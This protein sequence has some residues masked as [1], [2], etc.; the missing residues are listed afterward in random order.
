SATPLPAQPG[1]VGKPVQRQQS[2]QP[3]KKPA[4]SPPSGVVPAVCPVPAGK[5][6]YLPLKLAS[7][8]PIE[9]VDS[10]SPP[11]SG[12]SLG[13]SSEPKPMPNASSAPQR[14]PAGVVDH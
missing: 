3:G 7:N 2:V 13:S 5:P 12:P 8:Q 6:G 1:P 10:K 4:A 11:A 9:S 14:M